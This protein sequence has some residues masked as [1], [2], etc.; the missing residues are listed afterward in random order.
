[1]S[2]RSQARVDLSHLTVNELSDLAPTLRRASLFAGAGGTEFDTRRNI[3]AE[4]GYPDSISPQQYAN[5]WR[6]LGVARRVVGVYPDECWALDP[7]IYESEKPK[8][9][10][11]EKAWVELNRTHLLAHYMYRADVLSGIGQYGLIFF[12]LDDGK[13]P[14]EPVPG[15]RDDGTHDGGKSHKLLF[16][17]TYDESLVTINEF[18]SDFKNPRYGLPKTYNVKLLDPNTQHVSGSGA[19]F[20]DAVVHWTRV[21]HVADNRLSSE[22]WGSPRME[23]VFDRI[24]DIRKIL[25]GSGEMFWKGGFFGLSFESIPELGDLEI[26]RDSLRTELEAYMNGLQR[27]VALEGL[28]AKSLSPQVASPLDHYMCQLKEISIALGV[29]FRV[30]LGSEES[31][32]SSTQDAQ[33]WN[34]R[35]HRRQHKYLTPML[36]QPFIDRL[37]A[38]GV[39]PPPAKVIVAWPDLN[40]TTGVEKADMAAKRMTALATY[41]GGGVEQL[42]PPRELYTHFLDMPAEVADQIIEA[43]EKHVL[44]TIDPN[45]PEVGVGG[46]KKPQGKEAAKGPASAKPPKPKA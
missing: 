26:D 25:G 35:L 22:V 7:A 24:C 45:D 6:R 42:V 41:V 29:P 9:S 43:S 46:D 28:Q 27:Y 38:Y 32:L 21:L 11:F 33:T 14:K 16:L 12:G 37:V 13:N 19:P 34:K 20:V 31:K 15:F 30:F 17:R 8:D 39:L 44:T 10:D 3:N 5:A 23:P 2:N 36:V 1:M 40:T 4:C 18:E